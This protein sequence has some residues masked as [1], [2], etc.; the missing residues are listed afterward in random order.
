MSATSDGLP[1]LVHLCP[2][3]QTTRSTLPQ[4]FSHLRSAHSSDPS[5]RVT[6]GVDGCKKTYIKFSAL[7]THVYRHHR[8]RIKDV[9]SLP[10]TVLLTADPET[11]FEQGNSIP[12][13]SSQF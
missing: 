2:L 7:N 13:C 1:V 9:S 11:T 5:F 8:D 12:S 3:C 4:W 6:C 10:Q